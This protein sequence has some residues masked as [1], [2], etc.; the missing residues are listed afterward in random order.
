MMFACANIGKPNGGPYDEDPPK[1]VGSKPGPNQLNF[2][3]GKI[4]VYFDEYIQI[5]NPS[6]NV[7]ISPPQKQTPAI[8]AFGKKVSVELKDTLIENTTYSIDFTSSISD[9]TEKNI[10]ENFS[11]AFSTG[12]VLDTLSLSG[13]LTNAE[14]NEPM[15]QILVGIHNNLSDTA[16]TKIQFLR[17]SKTNDKGQFTIH[18]IAPGSY[19]VFAL[20]D[21][22]RNYAYDKSNNE[23]IAF[24]DSIII[25]SAE[26][27]MV[28]DT[29]W[30]DTITVDTIMMIEKSLFYPNNLHLWFFTDSVS[31]RQRFLKAER[32]HDYIFA[33]SFNPPMDTFPKPVPLNFEPAG[34]VWNIAQKGQSQEQGFLI[35]YWILDS[36]IYNIDTLKIE[37]SYWQ[38]N[39]S[40]PDIIEL[41]TDTFNLVNR[42][43]AQMKRAELKPKKPVNVRKTEDKEDSEEE[44]KPAVIPLQLTINPSGT[45]DT[46]DNITIK[47]NEPVLD[48]RKEFFVMESVVDTIF[49][50]VD[51]E[52]EKDSTQ[53]M[54]YYIKRPFRYNE[55]YRISV[56]SA[57]L[58]GVY[59]HCN[60][61]MSVNLTVKNEKEYGSLIVSLH[62][63]PLTGEEIIPSAGDND[64]IQTPTG[65]S[66]QAIPPAVNSTRV[67]PVIAELL[68]ST[69]SPV[70]TVIAENGIARFI[71]MI[72]DKYFF[73]VI[74]DEN[75]N[76]KWDAGNYEEKR[77]PERVVYFDKMFEVR[78][79]TDINEDWNITDSPPGAKP[80]E[81]LK[82]KPK[83]EINKKRDYKEESRPR[84]TN[85]TSTNMRG[86]GGLTR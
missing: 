7:I 42:E 46:Y 3:G 54:V 64:S 47:F 57:M 13:V 68:N 4:E 16:F 24:L 10:L 81:L 1:F 18:N 2:K 63:L 14:D 41:K 50:T 52:F 82:N 51:F 53:E 48:V 31:P 59:G 35:N 37:V 36:M 85:S 83:A 40:I 26:R 29:I 21:K 27:A 72:P 74:L 45:I 23:A 20:E 17:T 43:K 75:G 38:N 69:G 19:H 56:D 58:C 77:Q 15:Q 65:D 78:N 80:V 9:I 30:R 49:Q 86:L 73:R 60:N 33:L 76:G 12:D 55:S 22:N 28:A 5:D 67:M 66:I 71:D 39:D 6:E 25:P 44:K 84:N 32:P 11:Y 34:E 62:G 79:N 61:A 8:M 70:R